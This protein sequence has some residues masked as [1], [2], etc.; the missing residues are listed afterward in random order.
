MKK[1]E[2]LAGDVLAPF[3]RWWTVVPNS[4][5][6]SRVNET[7]IREKEENDLPRGREMIWNWWVYRDLEGLGC[8]VPH[9]ECIKDS[10]PL[11]IALYPS[12]YSSKRVVFSCTILYSNED[13]NALNRKKNQ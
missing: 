2:G 13:L 5:G 1:K 11:F 7:Y 3:G 6:V 8:R 4:Y 9:L 10:Q 12:S